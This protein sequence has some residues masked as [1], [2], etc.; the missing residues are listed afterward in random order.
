MKNISIITAMTIDRVIGLRCG[1]P[2][3]IKA[4]LEYFRKNTVNKVVIMGSNTF[5]SL[6]YKPL[7]NRQNIVLTNNILKFQD[8]KLLEIYN[9][10]LFTTTIEDSL[11]AANKLCI[12]GLGLVL[13]EI[14]VIGGAAI[15]KQFLPL[16]NKLYISVI[17]GNYTG[18]VYFPEFDLANWELVHSQEYAEFTA[19]VF[20][21]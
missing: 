7:A 4:E 16:S 6:N 14:M 17:K 5:A 21:R 2:W 13:P 12:N 3:R 9:N 8:Y 1:L 15:Y 18:D 19:Q 20:S 11:T 10:L